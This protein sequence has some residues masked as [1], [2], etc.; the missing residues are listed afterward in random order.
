VDNIEAPEIIEE[1]E[2]GKGKIFERIV[3]DFVTDCR[4]SLKENNI[5]AF[6]NLVELF[7]TNLVYTNKNSEKRFGNLSRQWNSIKAQ[8]MLTDGPKVNLNTLRFEFA[9]KKYR[10]IAELLKSKNLF[11]KPAESETW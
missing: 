10:L 7:Y 1:G 11:P 3:Y 5:K 9:M 8:D 6:C 4:N 2:V